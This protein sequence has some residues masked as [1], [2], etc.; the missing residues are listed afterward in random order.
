MYG[1]KK[2]TIKQKVL[3]VK[4]FSIKSE[5]DNRKKIR[6]KVF[7]KKSRRQI[8]E[9]TG[10]ERKIEIEQWSLKSEEQEAHAKKKSKIK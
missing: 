10:R 6:R 5:S 3:Q 9:K 7:A 2:G 4:K 8:Y 1:V